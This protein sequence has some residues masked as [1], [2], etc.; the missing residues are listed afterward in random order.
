MEH[1]SPEALKRTCATIQEQY[2][3][4]IGRSVVNDVAGKL[5]VEAPTRKCGGLYAALIKHCSED[6]ARGNLARAPGQ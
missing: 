5:D 1:L 2:K 6:L 3:A 4:C